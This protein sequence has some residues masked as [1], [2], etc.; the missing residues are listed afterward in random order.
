MK[1]PLVVGFITHLRYIEPA[2]FNCAIKA[3]RFQLSQ[4]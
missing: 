2:G 1:S 4:L 3:N